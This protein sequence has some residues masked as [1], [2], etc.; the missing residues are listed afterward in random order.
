MVLLT[1]REHDEKP[2]DEE[3]E[4]M[5]SKAEKD[6]FSIVE[7]EKKVRDEADAKREAALTDAKKGIAQ[8]GTTHEQYQENGEAE[9]VS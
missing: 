3:D 5:V 1:I 7:T 4:D 9:Q 6:F 8:E 2:D